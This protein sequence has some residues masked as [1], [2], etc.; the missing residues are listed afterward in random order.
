MSRITRF[1]RFPR[2]LRDY[3]L[4]NLTQ[5]NG[6]QQ[7]KSGR[8][9]NIEFSG[10]AFLGTKEGERTFF[11]GV[12]VANGDLIAENCDFETLDVRGSFKIHNCS[13]RQ[14]W[15]CGRGEIQ[16]LQAD[17]LHITAPGGNTAVK[18]SKIFE[19]LYFRTMGY[20]RGSLTLDNTVVSGHVITD[21]GASKRVRVINN[22]T[23]V[24]IK[25][26]AQKQQ[27]DS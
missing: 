4:H 15:F 19:N 20:R 27:G 1:F 22:P 26:E 21:P 13:M 17:T 24:S 16:S 10:Q 25:E 12:I 11:S 6:M 14:G 7:V 2:T 9:S 18:H 23:P 8:W 5:V 3:S